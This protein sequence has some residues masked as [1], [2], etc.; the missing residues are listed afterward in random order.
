[1]FSCHDNYL[2][3]KQHYLTKSGSVIF[4]VFKTSAKTTKFARD[5][6]LWLLLT[7][8]TFE[9][10]RIFCNF[11]ANC[12]ETTL[13]S[14]LSHSYIDELH[15]VSKINQPVCNLEMPI[16]NQVFNI[17]FHGNRNFLRKIDVSW[18]LYNKYHIEIVALPNDA[19]LLHY[20]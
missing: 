12:K 16:S 3:Y 2:Q 15:M 1:M 9:M 18:N 4:I 11:L 14:R 17:G 6:K 5:W 19:I 13:N 10:N 7:P 8:Q 20:W